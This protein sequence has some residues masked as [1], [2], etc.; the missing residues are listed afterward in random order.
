MH[1]GGR[2]V[3]RILTHADLIL[4]MVLFAFWPLGD[5]DSC[6]GHWGPTPLEG[7][8]P[9]IWHAVG[10]KEGLGITWTHTTMYGPVRTHPLQFCLVHLGV[11]GLA[12]VLGCDCLKEVFVMREEVPKLFGALDRDR[13]SCLHVLPLER[14]APHRVD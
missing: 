12:I 1:T 9:S 8:L 4:N 11:V 3:F 5:R 10:G 13:G 6:R 7:S 14:Q 2:P